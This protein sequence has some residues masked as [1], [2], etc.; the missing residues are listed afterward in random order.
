MFHL[1]VDL[2]WEPNVFF[3]Q[4]SPLFL[5]A[6]F[7]ASSQCLLAVLFLQISMSINKNIFFLYF[8]GKMVVTFQ[9]EL[10]QILRLSLLLFTSSMFRHKKIQCT[11]VEVTCRL[12]I[13]K[14]VLRKLLALYFIS[15]KC[16]R[17]SDQTCNI[18]LCLP[19]TYVLHIKS[20]I[21]YMMKVGQI[22]LQ[23]LI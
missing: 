15:R 20:W 7:F 22:L 23:L 18:P 14:V 16:L 9:V 2:L 5:S 3:W 1:K 6:G 17:I 10:I 8:I 13:L 12:N 21:P 4:V 19:S 11:V